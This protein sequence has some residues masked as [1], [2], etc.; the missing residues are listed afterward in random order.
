V[1]YDAEE[2]EEEADAVITVTLPPAQDED[3]SVSAAAAGIK[4]LIR[5]PG[6]ADNATVDGQPAANGTIHLVT[7]RAGGVT[8]VSVVLRPAVRVER[9]WG[10]AAAAAA[11]ED[12]NDPSVCRAAT[13][14][15]VI[16]HGALLYALRPKSVTSMAPPFQAN[17]PKV[18]AVQADS[19]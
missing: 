4:L 3:V 14:G 8:R 9:G 15:A 12:P 7:C 17:R 16:A 1:G 10:V 11:A 2:E 13:N 19:S 5:I 18:W 6:W